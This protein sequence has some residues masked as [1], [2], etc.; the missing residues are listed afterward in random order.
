MKKYSIC[1][2]VKNVRGGQFKEY[3]LVDKPEGE[4][5]AD[6]SAFL[7]VVRYYLDDWGQNSEG[8]AED[9]YSLTCEAVDVKITPEIYSK[10]LAKL[11]NERGILDEKME[12]NTNR[13]NF[14]GDSAKS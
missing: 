2:F 10:L 13:F 7:E 1:L 3:V 12:E 9:G 14:L 4:S 8:G 6:W 5:L 11:I